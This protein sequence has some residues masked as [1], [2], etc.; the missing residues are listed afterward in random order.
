MSDSVMLDLDAPPG[1][2]G[3]RPR[4]IDGVERCPRCLAPA[5]SGFGLAGGGYGGYLMCGGE[6]DCDWMWKRVLPP[7]VG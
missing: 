2:H 6:G 4:V 7:E 3:E 1:E 5:L